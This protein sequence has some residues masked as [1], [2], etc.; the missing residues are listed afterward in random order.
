MASSPRHNPTSTRS[1][2]P[3]E[4]FD[5][6]TDILADLV[7]ADLK[8]FPQ[9][10]TRPRIDRFSGRGNTVLPTQEATEGEPLFTLESPP[11]RP[12]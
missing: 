2:C 3:P 12:A 11:N 4:V 10:P 7:L 9:L 1:A 5:L 8:Q 6:I